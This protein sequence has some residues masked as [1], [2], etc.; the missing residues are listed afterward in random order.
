MSW[1]WITGSPGSAQL[2]LQGHPYLVGAIVRHAPS[3]RHP[4][5]LNCI[6]TL[7]DTVACAALG[8]K[9][10]PCLWS[11][12]ASPLVTRACMELETV[13]LSRASP[14]R[15]CSLLP[16]LCDLRL[17]PLPGPGRPMLSHFTLQTSVKSH[18]GLSRGSEVPHRSLLMSGSLDFVNKSCLL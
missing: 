10:N 14:S 7:L 12:L 3:L 17:P 9:L 13:C 6:S 11:H 18:Q 15:P 5:W 2:G 16:I 4:V 1:P 8:T